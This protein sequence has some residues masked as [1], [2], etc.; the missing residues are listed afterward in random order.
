[1]H[2]NPAHHFQNTR[3]AVTQA[4]NTVKGAPG[5]Y[6]NYVKS[7]VKDWAN[8]MNNGDIAGALTSH[9][10]TDTAAHGAALGGL[11]AVRI[12]AGRLGRRRDDD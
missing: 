3:P 2:N 1:M 4:I 9:P 6:K 8:K 5:A 7:N 10:I 11:A 12:A